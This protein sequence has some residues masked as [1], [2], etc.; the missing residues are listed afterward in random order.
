MTEAIRRPPTGTPRHEPLLILIPIYNDWDAVS[1]LLVSLDRVLT[2]AGLVARVL[3]VDDGSSVP[4]MKRPAGVRGA[5]VDRPGAAPQ[6]GTP[7]RDC[8]VLATSCH[9]RPGA[10]VIGR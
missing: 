1:M 2:E 3:L 7:A 10:V 5:V 4:L 9:I 6:R 8:I